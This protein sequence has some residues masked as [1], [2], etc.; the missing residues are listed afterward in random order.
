MRSIWSGAISFGLVNI[1]VKLYSAAKDTGLEFDMLHKK[2]FSPIRYARVCKHDG[3][4]IP[5]EE[6]VKG[7]EYQDGDY[8]I[9]TDDDFKK[10][11]LRKAKTIDI[12]EF[13]KDSE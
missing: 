6:I 11:N 7:Y 1:P 3:K 13:V 12:I 2:D 8:I 4:E 9:L 10:A 5:F